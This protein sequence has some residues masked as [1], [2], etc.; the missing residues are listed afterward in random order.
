[1][2]REITTKKLRP[3]LYGFSFDT[4]GSQSV[5]IGKDDVSST[6][7]PGPGR[8]TI[9]HRVSGRRGCVSVGAAFT[10]VGNGSM[11]ASNPDSTAGSYS[12]FNM[13]ESTPTATDGVGNGI[14]LIY[15]STN[16]DRIREQL[17]LGR[18]SKPRIIVANIASSGTVNSGINDFACTKTATGVYTITFKRSFGKTP[19][20]VATPND[21]SLSYATVTSVTA[22]GCVVATWTAVPAAADRG[23]HI[24]VYG[25]AGRDEIGRKNVPVLAPF[26]LPR[27]EAYRVDFSAGVPGYG[28][29][30]EDATGAPTDNG[31]LGDFTITFKEAFK[32]APIIIAAAATS[33]NAVTLTSVTATS[34]RMTVHSAAGAAADVNAHVLVLGSDATDGF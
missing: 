26:R 25:S 10:S 34:A 3:I 20:V 14:S 23:F 2:L 13:T 12:Q 19:I 29:G 9:N 21:A 18:F 15:Q 24:W 4:S 27:L 16:T 8:I 30:A 22:S 31:G 11:C 32:Q 5:T 1:M 7:D 6:A 17:V 28:L 33:G